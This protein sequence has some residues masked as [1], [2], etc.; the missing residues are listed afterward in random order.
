MRTEIKLKYYLHVH[1]TILKEQFG[2]FPKYVF[3]PPKKNP[4]KNRVFHYFRGYVSFREGTP[5]FGNTHLQIVKY[6]MHMSCHTFLCLWQTHTIV[7]MRHLSTISPPALA[8]PP[9]SLKR[10]NVYRFGGYRW[11]LSLKAI[12]CC[13]PTCFSLEV[14]SY[15]IMKQM[16]CGSLTSLSYL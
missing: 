13:L 11:R 7:S 10:S 4:L 16:G 6:N 8:H 3:F 15:M 5:I 2:C 14:N 1:L 12:A 9:Q